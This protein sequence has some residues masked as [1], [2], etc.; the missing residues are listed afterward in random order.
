LSPLPTFALLLIN[1]IWLCW[2]AREESTAPE[3]FIK[4]SASTGVQQMFMGSQN[5]EC[6]Y[7][8]RHSHHD[9]TPA[10]NIHNM[11]TKINEKWRITN[12]CSLYKKCKCNHSL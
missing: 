4:E 11:C 2:F 5:V 7:T 8:R 12:N 9:D 1:Y 10:I 6:S 3:A